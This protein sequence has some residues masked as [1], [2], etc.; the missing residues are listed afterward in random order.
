[1]SDLNQ[2][3]DP[4]QL[5]DYFAGKLSEADKHALEMQAQEDPFLYEAM[6][7]YQADPSALDRLQELL[8][9]NASRG[10]SFFGARTLS[11]LA[12][13]CAVYILALLIRPTIESNPD[14]KELV[15]TE[16]IQEVEIVPVSIDTF[17]L[18][19]IDEQITAQEIVSNKQQIQVQQENLQEANDQ[20]EDE[21]IHIDENH[22]ED[23]HDLIPE[24]EDQNLVVYAPSIFQYDLYVV[25]YRKID[26]K[27]SG[28]TYTRY[29]FTGLSAEFEDEIA[30]DNNELTEKEVE[31]PY[32]DYLETSMYYFSKGQYK[33]ALNRYLT[34]LEQYPDDLNAHFYGA[35]CYY[36]MRKYDKSIDFFDRVL[37]EE[38]NQ[39][40]IAFR[41]EAKW[42]KAK[43]LVKLGKRNDATII[44]DEIIMEGQF[45]AKEAIELKSSL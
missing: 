5:A 18:A 29:E 10:S 31:I 1:M 44:L 24:V 13:A 37:S 27:K 41:E 15:E 39:D 28:V 43:S 4:K 8:K 7:G 34:I 19:D 16:Q 3:I 17:V 38:F 40:F 36:S 20:V 14:Q 32:I 30:R 21:I 45:Y 22:V 35:L 9:A 6:E 12:V 2:H 25:D 42:Y 33:K 11:V 26:R 23:E